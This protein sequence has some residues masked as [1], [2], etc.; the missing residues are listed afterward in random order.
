MPASAASEASDAPSPETARSARAGMAAAVPETINFSVPLP[1]SASIRP[2]SPRASASGL[3]RRA[4]SAT[5]TPRQEKSPS[6]RAAAS[7]AGTDR[8]ALS[9]VTS[10]RTPPARSA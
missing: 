10:W 3:S 4:T 8:R 7:S 6:S 1:I 2:A 9:A 5:G